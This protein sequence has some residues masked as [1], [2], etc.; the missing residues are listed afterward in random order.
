MVEALCLMV[1]GIVGIAGFYVCK[2]VFGNYISHCTGF[3][4][5][6]AVP[7]DFRSMREEIEEYL[8]R[9]LSPTASRQR[10]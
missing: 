4:Y 10:A 5:M 1:S 6:L 9:Q 3:L 8:S 2:L 7:V